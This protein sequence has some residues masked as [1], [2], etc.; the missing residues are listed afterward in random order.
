LL[1]DEKTANE[2]VKA[3]KASIDADLERLE[4]RPIT[5]IEDIIRK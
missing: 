1:Y 5:K 4:N 2:K 3:L